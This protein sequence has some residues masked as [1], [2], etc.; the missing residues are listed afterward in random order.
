MVES[1]LVFHRNARIIDCIFFHS[2]SWITIMHNIAWTI[3]FMKT[4]SNSRIHAS[5]TRPQIAC[6]IHVHKPICQRTHDRS[7]HIYHFRNVNIPYMLAGPTFVWYLFI[8][9][10]FDCHFEYLL[11]PSA[12]LA[13]GPWYIEIVLQETCQ[14]TTLLLL[15][16]T[17]NHI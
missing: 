4:N 11:C 1:L 7:E 10:K 15:Y 5:S 13:L 6:I 2:N 3:H 8:I 9:N 14:Q 16:H 17:T 12:F